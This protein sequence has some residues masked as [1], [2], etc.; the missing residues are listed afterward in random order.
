MTENSVKPSHVNTSD[1]RSFN[2]VSLLVLLRDV[3]LANANQAWTIC[4]VQGVFLVKWQ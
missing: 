3:F 1:N 2:P 4:P